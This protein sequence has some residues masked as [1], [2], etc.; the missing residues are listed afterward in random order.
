MPRR[1]Y[2]SWLTWVTGHGE[3]QQTTNRRPTPTDPR[4][5]ISVGALTSHDSPVQTQAPQ[6]N[7]NDAVALTS[8][9]ELIQYNIRKLS[10][11]ETQKVSKISQ[12]FNLE[13][14]IHQLESQLQKEKALLGQFP[15]SDKKINQ[16][17]ANLREEV[18][19]IEEKQRQLST[20]Q[21]DGLKTFNDAFVHALK[22]SVST[23]INLHREETSPAFQK[24][25]DALFVRVR[26]LETSLESKIK[27]NEKLDNRVTK[28]G[29][30]LA[31]ARGSAISAEKLHKTV[32]TAMD[33]TQTKLTVDLKADIAAS[34]SE[35]IRKIDNVKSESAKLKSDVEKSIKSQDEKL[36]EFQAKQEGKDQTLRQ[37]IALNVTNGIAS[38]VK[39]QIEAELKPLTETQETLKKGLKEM[40]ETITQKV[41]AATAAMSS[42]SNS[43]N[44][45]ESL[46]RSIDQ[47]DATLNVT[48]GSGKISQTFDS[49]VGLQDIKVQSIAQ[50]QKAAEAVIENIRRLQ[51]N[52][53]KIILDL[54]EIIEGK[55]DS[56]QPGLLHHLAGIEQKQ[57]DL[58]TKLQQLSDNLLDEKDGD[59]P[60]MS[61]RIEAVE[62][63]ISNL[64][65]N[66]RATSVMPSSTSRA[67]SNEADSPRVA[68]RALDAINMDQKIKVAIEPIQKVMA[69]LEADIV[70]LRQAQQ[71]S[72]KPDDASP[73]SRSNAQT[74]GVQPDGVRHTNGAE[75]RIRMLEQT[76]LVCRKGLEELSRQH[77]NLTTAEMCKSI[78]DEMRQ[79][80]PQLS[81]ATKKEIDN[82]RF[83]FQQLMS[84]FDEL[85]AHVANFDGSLAATNAR[86][87]TVASL[88]HGAAAG[89]REAL[90]EVKK[91][92]VDVGMT[93][94]QL[95]AGTIA[96][97]DTGEM[98]PTLRQSVSDAITKLSD[99]LTGLE[100]ARGC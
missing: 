75:D 36:D 96:D 83:T 98:R 42:R 32:I 91:I 4:R 82:L 29:E 92:K 15:I 69:S 56:T 7:V 51:D 11:L 14:Q 17:L 9:V 40:Q 88:A 28:L 86:V 78:V 65:K 30:E 50:A 63:R 44:S 70:S 95:N 43:T 62:M 1:E 25:S 49:A 59:I 84:R 19:I 3:K 80:Y 6:A 33:T 81:P 26:N 46:K 67:G 12:K 23:E 18:K 2:V 57:V 64:V 77:Q 60:S 5:R 89:N 48:N 93:I 54:R 24:K 72:N 47:I 13:K 79:M 34:E 16:K 31:R 90:D 94:G 68:S 74:N 45:N 41:A 99:R 20:E 76:V 35:L 58:T 27:E 71:K 10:G 61:K 21:S 100:Q 73:A 22:T 66:S 38:K 39:E 87:D 85:K 8:A 53:H 97:L 55:D 52:H 37:F